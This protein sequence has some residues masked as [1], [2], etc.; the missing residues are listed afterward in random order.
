MKFA[1]Q[2]NV[3]SMLIH[4]RPTPTIPN[5]HQKSTFMNKIQCWIH[6]FCYHWHLSLFQ[7]MILTFVKLIS[8][9]AQ[10]LWVQTEVKMIAKWWRMVEEWA[11]RMYP[12]SAAPMLTGNMK[13]YCTCN[14]TP[15]L[16]LNDVVAYGRIATKKTVRWR[17]SSKPR[18]TQHLS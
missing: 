4:H 6:I 8:G 1:P 15:Y 10:L 18:A 13:G 5:L 7:L 14:V 12:A 3:N 16:L 11:Q 17:C 2:H 9:C